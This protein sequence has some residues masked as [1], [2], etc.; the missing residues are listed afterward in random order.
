MLWI[1]RDRHPEPTEK[2]HAVGDSARTVGIEVLNV[3]GW[4]T[5]GDA[6]SLITISI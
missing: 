2:P 4:L 3:G 6:A 1:G 5:R